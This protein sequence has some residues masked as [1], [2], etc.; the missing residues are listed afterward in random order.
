[1]TPRTK[2]FITRAVV[3]GITLVV[4][5]CSSAEPATVSVAAAP[6]ATDI[7]VAPAVSAPT[8]APTPAPPTVK[9]A[10]TATPEPSP[11]P[12]PA[13]VVTGLGQLVATDFAALAG[14]RVGVIANATSDYDGE[15][16]IDLLTAAPDVELVAAFAPEHGIRGTAD[17]GATISDA[18]D[19]V[20]GIP[21]FSLYGTE[22]APTA[23]N[24]DGIDVL[25]YDLQ[26]VGARYYTYI[27]T[28]GLA[29][30]AAAAA[31]VAFVVLDRPN[32]LGGDHVAGFTRTAE[33]E[34]FVSQYP[35]PS[36]YGLTAGELAT[37]IV[38]EGWLSGLGDLDLTI[39]AMTNWERG[40]RWDD[41]NVP[42]I[43]P[44]PGL[45]TAT[46]AL[47][48]PAIVLFEATTLSFGK[49]TN[50]PFRQLGAP[51][52]DGRQLSADL[53]ALDLAGVRF[54][55]V[56]FTPSSGLAVN[57]RHVD[58]Q[59]D[60]TEV[61]V[62]DATTFDPVA[63]GVHLMVAVQRQASAGGL[64]PIIDRPAFFDLLAG[65][66]SVRDG[67]TA[68][69]SADEIVAGWSADVAAFMAVHERYRRY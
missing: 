49:G 50:R 39:V 42:W 61:I 19:A 5:A 60:G 58:Q 23:A 1:M 14:Q 12:T 20:T 62:T 32:P 45:P 65:S 15:H 40:M 35:I 63:T 33:L 64:G 38:G 2:A 51:W 47:T 8:A 41:T 13:P 59:V 11:P 66:T 53:N 10:A 68:E 29:M 48:Y 4:A 7:V 54:D 67:L 30:Q 21:I 17:A 31:D 57:P 28:L 44:S 43:A 55:A 9:P 25:V 27:S 6:T 69:L 36:T 37:A 24:L 3:A 26:D 56:T 16:I 52:L 22:R 34:S 46:S 18:A